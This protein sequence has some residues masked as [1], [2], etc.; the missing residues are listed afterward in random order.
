MRVR[1][2]ARIKNEEFYSARIAAGYYT[3]ISLSKASGISQQTLSHYEN[4]QSFP[5]IRTFG[6]RNLKRAKKIMLMEELLRRKIEDLFPPEYKAAIKGEIRSRIE[7]IKNELFLPTTKELLLLPAPEEETPENQAARDELKEAV[8][9]SL[10]SLTD[11]EEKILRLRF[12][13]TEDGRELTLKEIGEKMNISGN[14]A[15]QIQA[16]A[17][18]KLKHPSRSRRLIKMMG[19][20]ERLEREE[21]EE[22]EHL[23]FKLEKERKIE[24]E[25][26]RKYYEKL[27]ASWPGG[28]DPTLKLR[29]KIFREEDERQ[30]AKYLDP[31]KNKFIKTY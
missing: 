10:K 24:R 21:K 17:I 23:K 29:E 13:M 20:G 18:R 30:K 5:R 31:E 2:I 14:R 27:R 26:L 25:K 19:I 4:F 15:L 12:G 3:I 22:A 16:K 7:F 6:N 11:R 8:V 28:E 9:E 1:V